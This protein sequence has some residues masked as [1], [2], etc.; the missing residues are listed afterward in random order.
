MGHTAQVDRLLIRT[1][2]GQAGIGDHGGQITRNAPAWV[3][4]KSDEGSQRRHRHQAKPIPSTGPLDTHSPIKEGRRPSCSL[5]MVRSSS[6]VTIVERAL[7]SALM[8][9]GCPVAESMVS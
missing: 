2:A 3:R 8:A 6:T 9:V 7:R 1:A 5:H 4:G